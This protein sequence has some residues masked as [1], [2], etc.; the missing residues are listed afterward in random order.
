MKYQTIPAPFLRL[1]DATDD[2]TARFAVQFTWGN[3]QKNTL[4]W[5]KL[6][7]KELKQV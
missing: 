4:K 2:I 6:Y 7:L 1:Q 5:K 3:R